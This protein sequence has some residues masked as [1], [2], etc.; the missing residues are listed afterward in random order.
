MIIQPPVP[1]NTHDLFGKAERPNRI[2]ISPKR[3]PLIKSQVKQGPLVMKPRPLMIKPGPLMIWP[4][5]IAAVRL[6]ERRAL[7][8]GAS[9]ASKKVRMVAKNG[10]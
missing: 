3:Q 8:R 4:N 7:R 9:R 1:Y 10:N 5:R 6:I 2:L